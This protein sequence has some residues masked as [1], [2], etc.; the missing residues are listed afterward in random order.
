MSRIHYRQDEQTPMSA[1]T[2]AKPITAQ[3]D[4][5]RISLE[6][7][8]A[9]LRRSTAWRGPLQQISPMACVSILPNK[10]SSSLGYGYRRAG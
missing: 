5:F 6:L 4:F 10:P 8:S 2:A 9:A 7:P 1:V 3:D